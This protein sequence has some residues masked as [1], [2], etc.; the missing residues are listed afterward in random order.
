M[1]TQMFV[2]LPVKDLDLTIEFFQ[3]LGFDFNP[4]FTNEKATCMIVGKDCF[5][6][7][8]VESFFKSFTNKEICDTKK[9]NEVIV[10]LS[11][12]TKQKVDDIVSKAVAAGGR[13]YSQAIDH[14]FAN[15]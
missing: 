9:N 3:K 5:A 6:M 1:S 10:C 4:K 2:N 14:G 13:T 11:F 15:S 8:L 7:L 12:E